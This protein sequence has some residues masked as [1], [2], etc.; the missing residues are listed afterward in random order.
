M[1]GGGNENMSTAGV[2]EDSF[3]VDNPNALNHRRRSHFVSPWASGVTSTV[4]TGFHTHDVSAVQTAT[5]ELF[6]AFLSC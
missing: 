2:I 3:G 1:S 6:H 5:A 4:S